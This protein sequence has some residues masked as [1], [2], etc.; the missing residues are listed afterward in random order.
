MK[1][2]RYSLRLRKLH[3][4]SGTISSKALLELLSALTTCAER[5]LRLLVEGSSVKTGRPPVWLEKAADF[6]LVGIR[7]GSTVLDLEATV[8]EEVLGDKVRQEDMWV[9]A[10]ASDDTA[11]S[12]VARSARDATTENME[13]DYYD[14]GVL[15][16][17]LD[18]RQF[19]RSHAKGLEVA[20]DD[21]PADAFYL[22]SEGLE[23]A[24]KV[25]V[26]LPEPAA[27]VVS[28]KLDLI[29]HSRRRFH[30]LLPDG[31]R[32]PGQ[33]DER[34]LSHE[35][36]RTFW[37]RNVTL[38]GM[39]HFKPS[40]KIKLLEAQQIREKG[41]GEEIFARVPVVQ[42]EAAFVAAYTQASEGRNWLSEVWGKWPGDESVE[43]VLEELK[44]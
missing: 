14:A 20:S 13:S 26:R 4:V 39:V 17:L 3:T 9:P 34:E 16:S 31:Q 35:E 44:R 5:E 1:S 36:L 2:V 8:L 15:S 12:L 6:T 25:R 19:F 37:G 29:E 42:T 21:K 28:G 30:V 18:L 27:F 32:L 7:E 41:P 11:I 10:P 33:I 43:E 24:E 38:K 23:K 22:D 40:G